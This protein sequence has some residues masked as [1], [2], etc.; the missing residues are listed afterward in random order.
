M[1][2]ETPLF[3][4]VNLDPNR[5]CLFISVSCSVFP[6]VVVVAAVVAS[7]SKL[8]YNFRC[9]EI[10]FPRCDRLSGPKSWPTRCHSLVSCS[11][12][13]PS[14][15]DQHLRRGQ[16]RLSC[17]LGA[18]RTR[19]GTHTGGNQWSREPTFLRGWGCKGSRDRGEDL[20]DKT[21]LTQDSD[22]KALQWNESFEVFTSSCTRDG[23]FISC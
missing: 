19:H 18:G 1:T 15:P 5:L 11:V 17:L 4:Y 8:L 16:T 14:R 9:W 21:R 12:S 23:N 7:T 20:K 10:L 3:D 22:T 6:V 2:R 13:P